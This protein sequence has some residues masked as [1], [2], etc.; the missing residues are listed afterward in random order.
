MTVPKCGSDKRRVVHDLSFPLGESVNSSIDNDNY[1]GQPYDCRVWTKLSNLF[2]EKV[3][4]RKFL[5]NMSWQVK[6]KMNL[7][8]LW[9]KQKI[10]W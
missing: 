7:G 4:L 8:N 1:L 5:F 3:K 6:D 9:K 2:G 10:F